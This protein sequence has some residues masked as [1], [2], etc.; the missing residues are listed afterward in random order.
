M[1]QLT[2]NCKTYAQNRL[3]WEHLFHWT[4]YPT[5]LYSLFL[6]HAIE[7]FVQRCRMVIQTLCRGVPVSWSIRLVVQ[8]CR[9]PSVSWSIRVVVHPCRGP[10]VSWSNRVVV[11]LCR[12]PSVSWSIRVVVHPCRGQTVSWS[13]RVVVHPCRGPSVPWSTRTVWSICIVV[14]PCRCPSVSWSIRVVGH[15]CR[16]PSHL[17]LSL[18]F[19]RGFVVPAER[20]KQGPTP[21]CHYYLYFVSMSHQVK[22]RTHTQVS[23]L[24]VF[25]LHVTSGC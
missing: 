2:Q 19:D 12:C 21:K 18:A 6:E 15:P 14:H 25:C 22:T 8:P 9:G 3:A 24:F 16:R 23:L 17:C 1:N 7:V 13:I 5:I 20:L 10:S 11:N 4:R